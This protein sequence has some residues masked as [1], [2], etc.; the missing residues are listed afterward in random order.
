MPVDALQ[1]RHNG[2]S[3]FFRKEE[4][5]QEMFASSDVLQNYISDCSC[6]QEYTRPVS[7]NPRRRVLTNLFVLILSDLTR[8]ISLQNTPLLN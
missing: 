6:P 3:S 4:Q 5:Q 2:L 1:R 8:N 7:E